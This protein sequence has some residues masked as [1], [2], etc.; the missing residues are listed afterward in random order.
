[1]QFLHEIVIL[2]VKILDVSRTPLA[3]RP[4]EASSLA[5]AQTPSNICH[6][7]SG[8]AHVSAIASLTAITHHDRQ[9]DKQDTGHPR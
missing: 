4:G 6:E 3:A 8:A 7:M 5:V 2:R 1:M 9:A